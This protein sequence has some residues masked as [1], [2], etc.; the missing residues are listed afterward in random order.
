MYRIDNSTAATSIPT[1]GAVGPNPNGFFTVGNPATNTPAT[2]LDGDWANAVQEELANAATVDGAT[3]S[4]TN[5]TQLATVLAARVKTINQ[6]IITT[7]GTY[8]PS[9]GMLF[10]VGTAKG[11]GGGGGGAYNGGSASS[12]A[13]G[14]GGGEG[15]A[16]HFMLTASQIGASQSVVIGAGGAAGAYTG[17][18]GSGG[19]TS[20]GSLVSAGGGQGGGGANGSGTGGTGGAGSYTGSGG[21]V[22]PGAPGGIGS[23]TAT[24]PESGFGGGSGGGPSIGQPGANGYNAFGAAGGGGGGAT[25]GSSPQAYVGGNGTHGFVEII[26]FIG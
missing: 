3:L 4:K 23:Y 10:V 8:T 16:V 26:E 25:S 9:A 7:S 6:V 12:S 11:G 13:A 19:T 15:C 17:A 21:M 14:G 2:V 20:I 5:R 22:I 24:G 1:P 18:A